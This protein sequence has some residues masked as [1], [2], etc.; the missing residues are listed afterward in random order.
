MH[1]T[2]AGQ[3]TPAAGGEDGQAMFGVPRGSHVHVVG[4]PLHAVGV[5]KQ[6]VELYAHPIATGHA[7][8]FVAPD[9]VAGHAA[10]AAS[11]GV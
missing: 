11:F 2:P 5:Q 3:A 7:A 4:C 8:P 1:W 6:H 9:M 10:A